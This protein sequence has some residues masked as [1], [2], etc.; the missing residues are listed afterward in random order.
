MTKGRN[1]E[2]AANIP[3]QV[4]SA[5]DT[6]RQ[7]TVRYK[8]GLGTAIEVADAQ[9]ILT[10]SEIDDALAK[11]NVWRAMLGIASASGNLDEFLDKTK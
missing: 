6:E 8:A 4:K 1:D 2:I 10:Q 5:R 7:A 11:L 3:L 9:R